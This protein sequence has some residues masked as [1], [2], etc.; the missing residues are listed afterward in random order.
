MDRMNKLSLYTLLIFIFLGLSKSFAPSE[1][2]TDFLK[3]E[4]V[5]SHLFQGSPL[6]LILV[7]RFQAGFL[8]NTYYLKIKVVHGFKEPHERVVRTSWQYWQSLEGFIGMSIFRRF[9]RTNIESTVPMPAG[10]IYIGDPAFGHWDYHNSGKKIWLFHRAYRQFPKIFKW[11]EY[12]PTYKFYQKY[13][14]YLKNNKPFFG[15]NKEFGTKGSL[16]K[17]YTDKVKDYTQKDK[18]T[19][20]DHAKILFKIPRW[21]SSGEH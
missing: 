7:D 11:G 5:L 4:R 14:T 3:N 12:T 10:I 17:M 21:N 1:K 16:N 13:L 15:I 6:S 9:E 2:R 20:I 18:T 19:F 8:I